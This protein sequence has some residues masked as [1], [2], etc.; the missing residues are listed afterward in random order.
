MRFRRIVCWVGAGEAPP[1]TGWLKCL[2]SYLETSEF[3][4]Q[5]DGFITSRE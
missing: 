2:T 4:I 3:P 1:D 5:F